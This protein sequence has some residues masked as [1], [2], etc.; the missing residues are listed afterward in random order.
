MIDI[1]VNLINRYL[2]LYKICIILCCIFLWIALSYADRIH[3]RERFRRI[4]LKI[5]K[6]FAYIMINKEIYD[7]FRI[8][9]IRPI[10]A[11]MECIMGLFE[12]I[13]NFE[14]AVFISE[15]NNQ[16]LNDLQTIIPANDVKNIIGNEVV[17][18]I[19]GNE[20]KNIIGNEV[21]NIISNNDVKINAE[22]VSENIDTCLHNI[23]N[24]LSN[25][26]IMEKKDITLVKIDDEELQSNNDNNSD[27]DHKLNGKKDNDGEDII[28][29]CNKV[30]IRLVRRRHKN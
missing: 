25:K 12:G 18:N 21:I 29:K 16:Y 4:G 20:V 7:N 5:S 2:N 23:L 15:N 3:L 27:D 10:C 30:P 17:K 19:I 24:E 9:V 11:I 14:A 26:S 1:I 13:E 22:H 28:K 8:L 6:C